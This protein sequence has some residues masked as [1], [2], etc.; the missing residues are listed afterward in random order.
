[1]RIGGL[2]EAGLA[3]ADLLALVA[4]TR[5]APAGDRGEVLGE[6]EAKKAATSQQS[7]F[8]RGAAARKWVEH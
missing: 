5:K 1:V 3:R 6:L 8:A 2:E 4:N 7:R